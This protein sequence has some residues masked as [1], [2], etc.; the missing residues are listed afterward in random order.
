[1]KRP[2]DPPPSTKRHSRKCVICT[3]PDREAIDEAFLHQSANHIVKDYNLPSLSS[4]YRHAHATGIWLRRGTVS[5]S[6]RENQA[7]RAEQTEPSPNSNRESS[8]LEIDP[9]PTIQTPP[10]SNR[11]DNAWY[12]A[13]AR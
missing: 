6:N 5:N 3:H 9:M 10:S 8:R 1:M 4:L 13:A 2:P 12:S 11:E 7:P